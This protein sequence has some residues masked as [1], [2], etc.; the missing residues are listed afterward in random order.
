MGNW[1]WRGCTAAFFVT[2]AINNYDFSS[3][4]GKTASKY[5]M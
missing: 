5:L 1:D 3:P 2:F 4:F